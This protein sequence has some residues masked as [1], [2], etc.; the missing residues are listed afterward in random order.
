MTVTRTGDEQEG[1]YRVEAGEW[2]RNGK[3]GDKTVL[4]AAGGTERRIWVWQQ[5]GRLG[6][7]GVMWN[8]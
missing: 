6:V 8:A 4:F 1:F 7:R 5:A 3:A 2:F